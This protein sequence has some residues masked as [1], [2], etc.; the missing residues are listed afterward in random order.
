MGKATPIAARHRASYMRA[1]LFL[2]DVKFDGRSSRAPYLVR[3]TKHP[4]KIHQNS[5][6]PAKDYVSGH[7]ARRAFKKVVYSLSIP[8]F[9]KVV[10]EEGM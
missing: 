6:R 8:M 7:P 9:T 10:A 5:N 3:A 4:K 2:T 1:F